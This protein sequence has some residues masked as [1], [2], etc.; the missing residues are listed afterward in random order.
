MKNVY[1]SVSVNDK[2]IQFESR[3][4]LRE[5]AFLNKRKQDMDNVSMEDMH[6]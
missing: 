6:V 1:S 5:T 4:K 2:L 3:M